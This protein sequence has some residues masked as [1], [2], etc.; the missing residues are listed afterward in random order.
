MLANFSSV[1]EP[2]AVVLVAVGRM[3]LVLQLSESVWDVLCPW[4]LGE[5]L[6]VH[7]WALQVDDWCGN[8]LS[9]AQLLGHE[10]RLA[11]VH[12]WVMMD[13]SRKRLI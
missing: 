13:A 11:L 2:C 7:V 4:D 6:W 12:L 3:C 5:C 10:S 9:L 1:P 8:K